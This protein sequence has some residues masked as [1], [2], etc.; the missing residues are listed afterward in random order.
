[1]EDCLLYMSC[2]TN[3]AKLDTDA[4]LKHDGLMMLFSEIDKNCYEAVRLSLKEP[5]CAYTNDTVALDSQSTT[6]VRV[7]ENL[8]IPLKPKV[9]L[10]KQEI[11][12]C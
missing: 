4:I 10:E 9:C 7:L 2:F 5:E 11:F 8:R 3:K 1:M 6:A 12:H